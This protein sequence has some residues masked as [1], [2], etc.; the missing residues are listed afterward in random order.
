M[1]LMGTMRVEE[2]GSEYGMKFDRIHG[3][4]MGVDPLIVSWWEPWV[5]SFIHCPLRY[6]LMRS[7]MPLLHLKMSMRSFWWWWEVGFGSW[8]EGHEG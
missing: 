4:L 1:G 7:L 3:G 5:M 6:S 2:Q 8:V